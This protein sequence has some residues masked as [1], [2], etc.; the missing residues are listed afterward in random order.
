MP[1]KDIQF[2]RGIFYAVQE[3][4][5]DTADAE[6][7]AKAMA[8]AAES[9]PEPIVILVNALEAKSLSTEARR[10]FSQAS[11]TPNVKI[12]AVVTLDRLITQQ[13]RMTALMSRVRSTHDTYFFDNLED[14]WEFAH[15][16]APAYD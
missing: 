16:H 15:K 11:E 4:H 2:E 10:I 5:V 14:A 1:I 12:G 8:D 9:S 13:S 3:G 6:A 7:W